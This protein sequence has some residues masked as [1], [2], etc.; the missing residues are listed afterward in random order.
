[1][2]DFP[3]TMHLRPSE[4]HQRFLVKLKIAPNPQ[5]HA[6]DSL[7]S[8]LNTFVRA[9]AAGLLSRNPTSPEGLRVDE[10]RLEQPSSD[11]IECVFD[12]RGVSYKCC[13]V[14][15]GMLRGEPFLD[16]LILSVLWKTITEPFGPEVL[17]LHDEK[18]ISLLEPSGEPHR[19]QIWREE[20]GRAKVDRLVRVIFPDKPS[21]AMVSQLTIIQEAWL[22]ICKG[23]VAPDDMPA[24]ECFISATKGYMISPRMYEMPIDTF[25]N[26]ELC[27]DFLLA[28]L[29]RFASIYMPITSVR[30][31]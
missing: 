10:F 2:N 28:G 30:I 18:A 23:G 8:I 26:I 22:A 7:L 5:T 6:M 15:I 13:R 19:F 20:E 24:H 3:V 17:T 31:Y 25:D 29:D 4:D 1:M 27:F 14:L 12:L 21:A 11:L 9:C 16:G